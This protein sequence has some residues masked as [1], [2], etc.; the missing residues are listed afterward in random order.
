LWQFTISPKTWQVTAAPRQL[1][2]G[3]GLDVQPSLAAGH[4]AFSVHSENA[5][6]WS[7]PIDANAGKVLGEIG[8]LTESAYRDSGPSI[9]TDGLKLVFNRGG[10]GFGNL[11]LKDL[12]S[13]K[14]TQ[15]VGTTPT[16]GVGTGQITAD[17]SKV[18]YDRIENQRG[19]LYVL[20]TSGGEAERACQD[21]RVTNGWSNDGKRI[22][23]ELLNARAIILVDVDS[24]HKTEILKH[25]KYG[26]SRGRFSPDDRWISF[27][28][29]TPSTRRIFIAPFHGAAPIP[30]SQWIPITDGQDMDRYASWSPDGNL[31]YFLSERE[32]FR[33]IWAQRLD[34]ATKHPLGVAFPVRHF[35]TSRRSLMTIG[36]PIGMGMSVAI[37]KIVFSMVER[38]GNIWMTNIP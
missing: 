31:L 21:C 35:H 8:R 4:L 30:E 29:I 2:F 19:D 28:S 24:G 22:V 3:A 25:P 10:S 18:A 38:T 20:P 26:L 33:C 13:G 5:N 12:K 9:S 17:G 37:D 23:Y 15:L 11:W 32:G 16:I 14:E 6:V 27:H 1:T 36:D 7:L 34:Q